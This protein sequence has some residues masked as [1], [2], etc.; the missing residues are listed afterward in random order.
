MDNKSLRLKGLSEN[1]LKNISVEIKHDCLTVVSGLSGSGKSSLAF[2]TV[3]AEGNRRYIETFSPYIRQF[4][5][6]SKRP[7][8][9]S[10]ENVRPALAIQQRNRITSSRSSVGSLTDINDYLSILWANLATPFS[11]KS[12]QE[13][14]KYTNTQAASYI[15]S[16]L[17]FERITICAPLLIPSKKTEQ[18][19]LLERL[20]NTGFSRFYT[21]DFSELKTLE[22][23]ETEFINSDI[24]YILIDRFKKEGL[25]C[26][27]LSDSIEQAYNL[28]R[29]IALSFTES[30]RSRSSHVFTSFYSE[31]GADLLNLK[32]EVSNPTPALFSASSPLGACSECR[33][34][35]SVLLPD[36]NKIIPDPGKSIAN[37]ALQCWSGDSYRAIFRRLI[38]FCEEQEIPTE[39][40]WHK[41]EPSHQDKIFSAKTKNF[42]GIIPFFKNLERKAYK[43]HV[44]FYL[45]LYRSQ[46][47][48]PICNGSRLKPA[49][50]C[51]KLGGLNLSEVMDLEIRELNAWFNSVKQ[52]IK[53]LNSNE[54][55]AVAA[56]FSARVEYLLNLGLPYLTL[57]RS[58]RTLSGGETQRVNLA[59][60]LGSDLTST[61]FVLDEPSVGLHPQDTEKLIK[62][63]RNLSNK[64][65]SVLMVEHDPDCISSADELIQMGPESG[66]SGG[67]IIYSGP[68][69]KSPALRTARIINLESKADKK[70]LLEFKKVSARNIS[71]LS[72]DIPLNCLCC[73]SGVSGSGKSTLVN[74]ILIRHYEHYKN[75][76]LPKPEGHIKGFEKINEIVIV[77]QSA[78]IKSPRST[79][80]S[81]SGIWDFIRNELAK[82]P[83]AEAKT[84][85][86]SAFSFNVDGGRCPECRG[87]GFMRED[88]QFLSDVY[89]PCS[90]CLGDR[91]QPAVLTV[92]YQQKNVAE[93]LKTTIKEC[94]DIFSTDSEARRI[95]NLLEELGLGHLTLGHPLSELSGGEAQRLKL[96]PYIAGKAASNNLLIF[97]EPTTGLH[98]DDISNLLRLFNKL[99]KEGNSILCIEHNQEVL[100]SADWIVDLGP[101]GGKNGGELLLQ[102]TVKDFL[103]KES[104]KSSR[105]A[106]FLQSY[107]KKKEKSALKIKP[108]KLAENK[109][110]IRGAKEHNLKNIDV[111]IEHNQITAITGVSGSGK[112]TI[113]KDIIYS[114]GQR[115]YLDCLSPYARQFIKELSKPSVAEI[116]NLRPT[117]CV[118]Q[119]TFLPGK[120]STVGTF[121]EVYNYLRLLYSKLGTQYCLDHPQQSVSTLSI[122]QIA[123]KVRSFNDKTV[124]LLAPAIKQKKGHHREVF[125][126][127][128]K[129]EI[130]EVRVDGKFGSTGSFIKGLERHKIHSIDYVWSKIVPARIPKDLLV[131]AVEEILSISGGTL[132]LHCESKDYIFSQSRACP[133]CGTGYFKPDPEDFSFNS[134]RGRCEDCE[135]AG[136]INNKPCHSCN[137]SRLKPLGLSVKINDKDIYELCQ[138]NSNEIIK[139]LNNIKFEKSEL[140]DTIYP[141]IKQR[142][143][144]LID[145]GLD[146]LPLSRPARAVSKGELQRLRLANALGSAL[147]GSFYIFD[148]PT[149]GLHK[150]DNL[151]VIREIKQLK[152]QGNTVLIIEHDDYTI[153]SAENLIVMGPG[154]G[155]EGGEITWSGKLDNFKW[156]AEPLLEK[157][158]KHP[159]RNYLHIKN[160]NRNNIKNLDCR[161][162]LQRLVSIC[163]VSGA[164]K[165]TLLNE[166]VVETLMSAKENE[167]RWESDLAKIKSDIPINKVLLVDQGPIGKNSRSTPASF[168]KIWDH[169]RLLFAQTIEAKSRG[170]GASFFSY[171]SGKGRC[172]ECGG[173]G[174]QKL[175][176]SFLADA[177]IPCD[178]CQSQRFNQ[179]AL[180]VRYLGLNPAE[181]LNLTFSEAQKIFTNHRKIFRV[182]KNICDLGL[183]YL[184]LGQNSATLSGGEC[185]RLKLALELAIEARG[186][187]LYILDE[188]TVGLHK[189]DVALL[190]NILHN[191]TARGDSV[192]VIEHDDFFIQHSDHVIEMGPGAGELGGKIINFERRP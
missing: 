176:M 191:L 141:E 109:L 129:A 11:L 124:R 102:G 90:L 35:G 116:H 80:A 158:E 23:N 137:G 151:K 78:L 66:I 157:T 43:N 70:N 99:V 16:E 127:A 38:A 46:F 97:D 60:A 170:W 61:Q 8:I 138:L 183:G 133:I 104:A 93:W 19:L 1:N 153:K 107:T 48:C 95:G 174:Q 65:N 82:T 20:I 169:I 6:K 186:H 101:E 123:D 142:L 190:L 22:D 118:Y 177:F 2:D 89:V 189:Q 112:S 180:S 85:S 24:T 49:S 59:A 161:L 71:S 53:V 88:M 26:K 87:A 45:S 52:S 121:S 15:S 72:A 100:L 147:S 119:H 192:I 131:N 41:L 54:I 13:L 162:P 67:E 47:T 7:E 178:F 140:S 12:G 166:I 73:L 37:Q 42:R 92:K 146:Y 108:E 5:D 32:A 184:S 51:F 179:D 175:E 56:A 181:M 155:R 39:I 98:L 34:F 40:P 168:L 159:A 139:F 165:S 96:V 128:L 113:A 76:T 57:N 28:S 145:L 3:Y 132:I 81:Y 125:T 134:R 126:K 69:D 114:E 154:G 187:T 21:A 36:I 164:G 55:T 110:I 160:A 63:I 163:G 27:R 31:P 156:P 44:R 83:E 117:I 14:K 152:D 122:D 185:Q 143:K 17:L 62:A 182:I 148:E 106:A 33:G 167:L 171:N 10:A 74:E 18:K 120:L 130:L 94:L 84:L 150:S 75:T 111:E 50:L 64:G 135:G 105:T 58:A 173:L 188:P 25:D 115:R 4:L 9:L 77:D 30:S 144:R 29:G 86:K 91:F 103:K 79:I 149:A 172:P 136:E 68:A